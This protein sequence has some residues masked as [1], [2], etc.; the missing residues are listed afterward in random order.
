MAENMLV[1]QALNELKTLDG[2]IMRAIENA[3][4]VAGA[5]MSDK[6]VAPGYTKDDFNTDATASNQSI[7]DMIKR[8]EVIK[9]AVV[10]SNAVTFVEDLKMTVAQAI[11]TKASIKY[12]KALL[13]AMTS[14]YQKAMS[15]VNM[16]NAAV[17]TQI[18][19]MIETMYGA[20]G[21]GKDKKTYTK[22]DYDAIATP[23]RNN[24]GWDL[25]DPL[26]I[27]EK[28]ETLRKE[29]EDFESHVDSALQIS[30]CTT[31]ITIE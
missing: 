5:K 2:R 31:I 6:N 11:E 1:T 29:I 22:E 18:D 7:T 28:I 14:Q 23:Y 21:N 16:K 30:N 4:F 27:K 8:R 9:A 10:H 3:N 25:V 13:N 17:D 24:N 26:T 12:K 19:R 15:T 20:A